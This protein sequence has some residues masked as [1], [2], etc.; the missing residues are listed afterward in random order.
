V[1]TLVGHT[2]LVTAC[3]VTPDGRHVVSASVDRTLKVWEL[4]S[5]RAVAT[6]AGHT[7]VAT[8]CAMTPDGRH[9]VSASYDQTL[10]V[11]DLATYNCRITHRGDARYL[12]V[13]V[14]ATTI[15][16]GDAAGIVWFLDLPPAVR[17]VHQSAP[18]PP[19][20]RQ[21]RPRRPLRK[22]SPPP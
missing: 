20:R 19:V 10:K 14:S 18:Q 3:A 2:D 13:A 17:S 5:G 16:A 22:R 4:G 1:A 9:V 6:L 11:W 21:S 15:M 8:A 12:A 7:A